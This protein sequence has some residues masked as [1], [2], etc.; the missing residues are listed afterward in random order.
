MDENGVACWGSPAA[1]RHTHFLADALRLSI[2]SMRKDPERHAEAIAVA[3]RELEAFRSLKAPARRQERRSAFPFALSLRT[4]G[5]ALLALGLF[6][7]PGN[8]LAKEVVP[9]RLATE[10]GVAAMLIGA[11]LAMQRRRALSEGEC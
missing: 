6:V 1:Q 4:L 10:F 7:L 11:P 3:E 9:E 5:M 2:A 8:V